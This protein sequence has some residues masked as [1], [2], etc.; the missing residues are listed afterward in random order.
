M[1]QTN[2]RI[3]FIAAIVAVLWGGYE[4][5][6][7]TYTAMAWE[8]VE[9]T[10]VDLEHRTWSCGK[11][12]RQCFVPIIG[13]HVSEE[14]YTV[15]AEK[16]FNRDEP[17]HLVGSKVD[18]YYSSHNP[19]D[20]TLGGEYGPMNHGILIFLIGTVVLIIFWFMR[21]RSRD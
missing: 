11:G 12:V 18:V 17:K 19:A 5:A 15:L 8:K 20:A 6:K 16:K 1:S 9:G 4:I 7:A 21:G 14:Y 10:I 3:V 13:Y 2:I